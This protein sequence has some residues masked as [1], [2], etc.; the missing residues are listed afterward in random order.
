MATQNQLKISNA[1]KGDGA[2]STKF[3]AVLELGGDDNGQGRT[4]QALMKSQSFPG[5]KNNPVMYKYKGIDIPLRGNTKFDDTWSCTLLLQEDHEMKIFLEKWMTQLS[6]NDFSNQDVDDAVIGTFRS[7]TLYKGISIYQRNF[8][9][10]ENMIQYV[11]HNAFP[12]NMNQVTV[13]YS[14]LGEILQITVEFSFSHY[15]IGTFIEQDTRSKIDK[16]LDKG[17]AKLQSGVAQI[18]S[19]VNLK[20]VDLVDKA[21]TKISLKKKKN[22]EGAGSENAGKADMVERLE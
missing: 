7:G 2:R 5:M 8:D 15:T 13:D 11:L 1:L 22:S 18:K 10:S 6:H 12:K 20:A 19:T 16:L 14:A 21:K 4:F 3:E 17:R 9:D